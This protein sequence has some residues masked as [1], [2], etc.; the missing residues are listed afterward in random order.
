MLDGCVSW[1][2]EL[3]ERYRAQGYWRGES[4]A[5]LGREWA[6]TDPGR[7]ALVTDGQRVSY[8]DLDR[9]ADRMAAGLRAHGI[10][11]HDRVVVQ[12]PNGVEFVVLCL[13]LFRLGALPVLALPAHRRA[14]I[15]HLCA[16][17]EAVAYVT[18][19]QVQGYDLRKLAADVR[20]ETPSLREVF[21]V[22]DPGE[23]TALSDVDADPVPLPAP[24]PS[25]VAFFLLSGGSTGL[26]KLIPR[27]HD[28]YAYQLR[29]TAA[30]MGFGPDGVY[31]AAL[32]VAHNAALGCPGVLGAL[33][34]GATAV[35]AGSPSPDE[36]FRLIAR[37]RVTLTTLMPPFLPL[38]ADL[39][40]MLGADLNGLVVEVG[41]ANLSPAVA[42]RVTRELGI[43]LAHF[44]G[45]AEG[46]ICCTRPDDPPELAAHT[47]GRP[48]SDADEFQVV[49]DAGRQVVPGE[50]GEL[51]VRG[52]TTLR[53]YYRVPEYNARTFT[54]DGFLRT[55]DLVRWTPTGELVVVGRIKEVVNRGGEK[56]PAGEVE[57]HL[58]A[59]PGVREVAVLAVPDRVLGE[60]TCAVVVPRADAP[61]LGQLRDFL[62]GRG[63]A[64]YKLP[65]RLELRTALP[66]TPVGKVD[67]RALGAELAG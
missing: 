45:M 12:L 14:E 22:G 39:A 51:I 29:A 3:A 44:F 36:A 63:L 19:D 62:T 9:R 18:V 24:D 13:S 64:A 27:T 56:V 53:G 48:L 37:E 5:D 23:F 59:H 54:P 10:D 65:D 32:P 66:H 26:P 33:R 49:D 1:P 55:G 41:G 30:A 25:D 58:L 28:D 35:L 50:V 60:K 31:L 16:H 40:P 34:V 11:R 20:A 46:P 17:T 2:R 21:V 52:P 67:K 61:T 47:Q 15:G 6:R 38:W 8:G 43:R 4:L 42:E 57:E 7:T